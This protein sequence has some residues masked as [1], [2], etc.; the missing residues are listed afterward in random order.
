MSPHQKNLESYDL[1]TVQPHDSTFTLQQLSCVPFVSQ[2]EYDLPTGNDSISVAMCSMSDEQ[3][4]WR[5]RESGE[6]I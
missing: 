3:W 2:Q 4:E 6:N 1:R 5:R